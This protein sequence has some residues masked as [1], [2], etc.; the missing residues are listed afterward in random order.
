MGGCFLGCV[1]DGG[2][3]DEEACGGF[4]RCRRT[5]L[6]DASAI[7]HTETVQALLSKGADV[8]SKDNDG[9]GS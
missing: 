1:A 3:R 8:L 7:G 6:H 5:V 4:W 2:V 9:C